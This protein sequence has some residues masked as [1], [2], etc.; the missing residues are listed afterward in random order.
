MKTFLILSGLITIVYSI[1]E[2]VM[3]NI[4][5]HIFNWQS[6]IVIVGWLTTLFLLYRL[7]KGVKRRDKEYMYNYDAYKDKLNKTER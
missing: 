5:Y 4:N 7:Y 3:Y 6:M 2:Y 1:L